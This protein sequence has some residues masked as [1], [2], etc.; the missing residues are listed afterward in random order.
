MFATQ[1]SKYGSSTLSTSSW[2]IYTQ[3]T[4]ILRTTGPNIWT[5]CAYMIYVRF[6]CFHKNCDL[7]LL[8]LI[9]CTGNQT[10]CVH[11][12]ESIRSID[13]SYFCQKYYY[14]SQCG[15]RFCTECKCRFHLLCS[16]PKIL[17]YQKYAPTNHTISFIKSSINRYSKINKIRCSYHS[18]R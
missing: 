3:I 4:Y 8:H 9:S 11:N 5:S 14:T 16:Y 12:P 18:S 17:K 1:I 10:T 13:N 6:Q 7:A 15:L 2:I